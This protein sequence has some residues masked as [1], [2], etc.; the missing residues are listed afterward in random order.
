LIGLAAAAALVPIP[1][2][3]VESLYSRGVYLTIERHLTPLSNQFSWSLLDVL[4][5]GGLGFL[6]LGWSVAL[7]RAARGTRLRRAGDLLLSTAA[8]GACVYLVFLVNWGL[9]YRRVPL[10]DKLVY[11]PGAITPGAQRALVA[12]AVD[13]LNHLYDARTSGVYPSIG[14]L[15]PSLAG[16]FQ[17]VQDEL[18]IARTARPA[19]PKRTLLQPYFMR[20]AVDGMTDPFLLETLVDDRLL[21]FERP[22]VI[23]HEWAHLAG[24]ADESEANFI[25]W[26]TCLRSTPADQY[27][28]W[29][30]L[31]EQ[32][33]VGL[34][35]ADRAAADRSLA[36]GP[37][38]DLIAV[39]NRVLRGLSPWVQQAGWRIYDRYLKA[40]NVAAGIGSYDAVIRLV[41]GTKFGPDW[42][43]LIKPYPDLRPGPPRA[44]R[45]WPILLRRSRRAPSQLT[46]GRIS[47][48]ASDR[49]RRGP[50]S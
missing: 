49:P 36:E 3:W 8:A 16:A 10:V 24:Y 39:R 34:S 17:S 13:A 18:G 20:A 46:R 27:S 47:R 1:G 44:A 12:D 4:L 28:G 43:P 19:V 23:A 42:R 35:V 5:V 25:G 21:P 31:Y 14:Q 41:L 9:N 30:F 33:L 22:F 26:L 40:N 32:A 48:S 45:A 15:P 50:L 7:A 38:H 29:Q 2:R 11:E 6:I 37:R